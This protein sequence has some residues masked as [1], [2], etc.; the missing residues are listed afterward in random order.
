[1]QGL[2]VLDVY[3][4]ENGGVAVKKILVAAHRAGNSLSSIKCALNKGADIVELD[5]HMTKDYKLVVGHSPYITIKNE[6]MYFEEINYSEYSNL[7]LSL[8]EI[9]ELTKKSDFSLLVD[10]KKGKCFYDKIGVRLAGLITKFQLE[11]RVQVISFDH[12]ALLEIKTSGYK[13]IRTGILYVARL[14]SLT[15][16]ILNSRSD[17]V[18]ICNDY[19]TEELVE[20]ARKNNIYLC[21]WCADT[22]EEIKWLIEMGVDIITTNNVD[23]AVEIISKIED[24]GN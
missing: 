3:V 24:K 18:E 9:F 23:M 21:G 7:I 13:K 14:V 10:I 20:E 2:L 17:F 15:D 12:V 6:K 1:M 16:A 8:E 4:F 19:L 22:E 11:E 5:V